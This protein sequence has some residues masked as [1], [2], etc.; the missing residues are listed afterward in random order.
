MNRSFA[1]ALAAAAPLLLAA[2]QPEPTTTDAT[3]VVVTPDGN[4]AVEAPPPGS[5]PV[6]VPPAKPAAGGAVVVNPTQVVSTNLAALAGSYD[7]SILACG[8][9]PTST[10]VT[11]A[12]STVTI[13]GSTCAVTDQARDGSS[14]RVS[15]MCENESGRGA[16]TINVTPA[17]QGIT[18]RIGNSNPATL[19]RCEA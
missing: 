12:A 3:P 8:N 19:R 9:A 16:T 15:L 18:L 14:V 11:L 6:V 13:G 1:L 10:R 7:A 2:C 17:A 5:A 4:A